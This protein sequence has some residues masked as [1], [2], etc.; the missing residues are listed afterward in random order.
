MGFSGFREGEFRGL[1]WRQ[2]LVDLPGFVLRELQ[3]RGGLKAHNEFASM[4]RF[5]AFMV[6]WP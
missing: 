5:E 2:F 1:N 4:N 3:F 6:Y